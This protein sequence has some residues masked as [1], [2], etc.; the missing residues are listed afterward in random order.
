INY[1]IIIL[2]IAV[3]LFF[4][5]NALEPKDEPVVLT[6]SQKC[7]E[8]H[9][10]QNIRHQ[11]EVWEKSKH[12]SAY[13]ILASSVS[14][15]FAVKNNLEEPIKNKLCLR[16]HSTEF[17]LKNPGKS[18]TFDITEGVGCEACHG[19]GSKY[20]PADIMKD[21]SLFTKNGGI[22]G[23]ETTCHGCHSPK[24]NKEQKISE[25]VCPFQE[26]DFVYY[27][28]FEK[29]KHPIQRDIK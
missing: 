8:G 29:I 1:F 5:K 18:N 20:S 2:F 15:E 11:S 19:A 22:R 25:E 3:L 14:T 12:F 28:E 23:D 13:K 21:N 9:R 17:Y 26:N 4:L 10:L 7:G 6:G 24:G 16:C 27:T